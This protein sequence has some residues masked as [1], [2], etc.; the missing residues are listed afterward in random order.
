VTYLGTPVEVLCC[1][2]ALVVEIEAVDRL[3]GR[4]R[5]LG[6]RGRIGSTK[7]SGV[8]WVT[9][10]STIS[11]AGLALAGTVLAYGLSSRDRRSRDDRNDRRRSYLDFILAVETAHS[12]LRRLAVPDRPAGD[13]VAETREAMATSG[14]YGAREKLIITADRAIVHAG[15]ATLR[16]LNGVRDA[17]RAGARL[18]TIDF[19]NAYHR[20]AEAVWALR[21]AA[22]VD[23]GASPISPED[24]GKSSWDSQ[25]NCT[26]CRT[27][28]AAVPV[29]A[30]GE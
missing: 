4:L 28:V 8:D 13:I 20:Y 9:I 11:G 23:L 25:Q 12:S 24:L 15:E 17:V 29:R 3:G 6:L 1:L 22:R 7:M 19:H 21:R 16:A 10:V 2:T 26:F 5:D 30:S 18:N 27:H 14:V